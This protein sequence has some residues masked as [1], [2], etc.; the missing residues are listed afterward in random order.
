MVCTRALCGL[1]SIPSA[2][3]I[4]TV[5]GIVF[6]YQASQP[7]SVKDPLAANTGTYASL[8]L[9]LNLLLTLMIVTRLVW[10][11]TKHRSS[12]GYSGRAS[13]LYQAVNTMLI[14]SSALFTLNSLLFIVPRA[15]GSWVT[16]IFLPVLAETQVCTVYTLP[17]F[18]NLVDT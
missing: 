2:N 9:A 8:S 16:G 14:G 4:N 3:Y 10:H 6:L 13:G 5:A 17:A 18:H 12:L 15:A 7:G 11:R 1:I